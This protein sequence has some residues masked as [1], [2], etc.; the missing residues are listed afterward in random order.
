MSSLRLIAIQTTGVCVCM[1]VCPKIYIRRALSRKVSRAAVTNKQKRLQCPSE[2]FSGK[3]GLVYTLRYGVYT[4][5]TIIFII[6]FARAN[7]KF[8]NK[9]H[10]LV[11][12]DNNE[13]FD[14]MTSGQVSRKKWN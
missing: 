10:W 12:K 4:N 13:Y 2:L 8:T 1:Y 14:R 7:N 3:V 6:F 11:H 5:A 9:F